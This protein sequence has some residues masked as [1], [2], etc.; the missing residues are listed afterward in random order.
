MAKMRGKL[1]LAGKTGKI[2]MGAIMVAIAVLI[3]SGADKTIEARLV[4][5][6]PAWLTA[7]TTRF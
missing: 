3:L 7:L 5:H 6:S 4:S 1:M 2:A